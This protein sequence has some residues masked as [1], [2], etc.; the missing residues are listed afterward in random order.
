MICQQHNQ[1]HLWATTMDRDRA[2]VAFYPCDGSKGAQQ[3]LELGSR[4]VLGGKPLPVMQDCVSR[5]GKS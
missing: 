5:M 1:P 4:R 2:Y 3:G